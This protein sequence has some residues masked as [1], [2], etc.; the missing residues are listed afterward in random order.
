M[1][2]RNS[3]I[4]ALA[5]MVFLIAGCAETP[6]QTEV[7]PIPPPPPTPP[8]GAIISSPAVVEQPNPA[9]PAPNTAITNPV[10]GANVAVAVP[11]NQPGIEVITNF[12]ANAQAQQPVIVGTPGG[13]YT[14][15]PAPGQP[16]PQVEVVPE[17]PGPDYVWADGYWAWGGTAWVWMPGRW[18]LRPGANVIIVPGGDWH[19]RHRYYDRWHRW[20]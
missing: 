5:G 3:T 7:L 4:L 16:G 14:P 15:A 9:F 6:R 1:I 12:Q 8:P 2:V 17:R 11:G 13:A 19:Y 18:V 20:P 10:P